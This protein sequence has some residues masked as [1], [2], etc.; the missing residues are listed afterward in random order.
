MGPEAHSPLPSLVRVSPGGLLLLVPSAPQEDRSLLCGPWTFTVL[1]RPGSRKA[2]EESGGSR[3]EMAG[4]P[5]DFPK[6]PP[7]VP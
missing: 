3:R 2:A 4:A 5:S 6:L 7:R 1:R